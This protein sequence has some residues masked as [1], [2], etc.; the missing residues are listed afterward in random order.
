MAKGLAGALVW[1]AA[2][3]ALAGEAQKLGIADFEQGD[4]GFA[5]HL[6]AE[7]PGAKGSFAPAEGG[8]TGKRAAKIAADFA[9]GGVYVSI[10]KKLPELDRDFAEVRLWVRSTDV[11]GL[12][13]RLVDSTGQVHQQRPKFEPDGQWQLIRIT[14]FD[15]GPG[16]QSWGGAKDRKWHPPATSIALNPEKGN[17]PDRKGT[18]WVDG[19]EATLVAQ[20]IIPPLAVRPAR[21]GNVFLTTEDVVL[22]VETQGDRVAWEITDFWGDPVA[23]GQE[24][25]A[26]NA[27][28]VRPP[29]RTKGYFL[30]RL[31]ATRDG[32]PVAE[33]QTAFGVVEPVDVRK[34][35]GNRFGVQAHFAQGWDVD[36]LPLLARAGIGSIRDEH[37]WAQVEKKRGEFAFPEKSDRYMAEA[38]RLGLE[39]LVTMSFEN[40][41]HDGGLT[42]HTPEGR[43]AYA[44]YGQAIL[45]RYGKQVRHLEVWNEY[46]GT[47][48]KGPAAKDRPKSYAQML[49]AAWRGIKAER[50]DVRVLGSA[51]VLI[52]IPYFEGIFRNGGL[53]HMDAVVIHPYRGQPEGVEDEVAELQELI[54]K[55]NG[56]RDKPIWATETGRWDRSEYAW[57]KGQG[58][59]ELGRR[60]VARYLARQM[61]LLLSRGVERV[62]WYLARDYHDF[63]TM[64]LLRR[65]DS[66]MGRY[67]VAAPYMAYATLIRQ[68]HGAIPVRREATSERTYVHLF[69]RGDQQVR[70]CWA[71]SPAHVAL[72]TGQPVTVVDIVGGQ[73]T[74]D[75]AGGEVWLTLSDAPVYVVG[76]VESIVEGAAA[77]FAI[78]GEQ[79]VDTLDD[80]ALTCRVADG[81]SGHVA[82]AG[83]KHPVAPGDNRLVVS[84]ADTTKPG[85]HTWRYRLVVDGKPAGRG[86]LVA[87]VVDPVSFPEPPR[88]EDGTHLRVRLANSSARV[89]YSVERVTCTLPWMELRHRFA[90]ALPHGK[91]LAL[92]LPVGSLPPYRA[93]PATVVATLKGRSGITASAPISDNPCP[94]RSIEPDG[95]L[96]DWA[97]A[98]GIDLG[99]CAQ[100][101]G[102]DKPDGEAWIAWDEGGFHFALRLRS[103][104]ASSLQLALAPLRAPLR[105]WYEFQ[106]ALGAD[107]ATLT[108]TL[109]PAAR[110]AGAAVGARASTARADGLTV[111]EVSVPWAEFAPITRADG[112]FRLAFL[113][114][115][116]QPGGRTRWI[117]WGTG[118]RMGKTPEGFRVCRFAEAGTAAARTELE[119][120]PTVP[121]MQGGHVVAD[122]RADYGKVQG[123]HD[124]F[125]GFCDGDAKGE[126]DGAS[127][128]GAYTDDDFEPMKHIVTVWGYQWGGPMQYL[129]LTRDGGHPQAQAGRPVWAVRRWR[130]TVDGTVRLVGHFAHTG[131]GDGIEGRILVGGVQVYGRRVGG[132]G[133]PAQADFEADVAVREGIFVDF[134]ITPGPGTDT[135]FD[136]STF[137]V[138]II[139]PTAAGR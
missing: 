94:K 103:S 37:Y 102:K 61:T 78:A 39:P 115:E 119:D 20:R 58:L 123:G 79:T 129:S 118:I 55:H 35:P 24:T 2:A 124:W 34:M 133:N 77:K 15:K 64:G 74:L 86:S 69:R 62:Y 137:H 114:A 67:N 68:L 107:G 33:M 130:S 40:P 128:S 27:A 3:A 117:E 43:D 18:L 110:Q 95:R 135:S 9:G 106:V 121:A 127:P 88:V 45:R 32:K 56:G 111:C 93:F 11:N 54:R 66:P 83:G 92:D 46:N 29:S 31:S 30:V 80:L 23:E 122:S 109:A 49:E 138:R 90:V 17:F 1:L 57:E 81:L 136:A 87:R 73:S 120:L 65:P 41:L 71:T 134:A 8:K 75:P 76:P 59:F 116:G 12:T 98:V 48:C 63:R 36:I 28:T 100:A 14:A 72:R 44:R 85:T 132:Q 26:N 108:R 51:A 125:Y 19:I 4:D 99:T 53:E 22:P 7:F 104:S 126:G 16:Y 97:G 5:F 25:V 82:L 91:G 96:D 21:L 10:S 6:G 112:A 131:K 60:N 13:F 38:A 70:V 52:P 47:W 89:E 105:G 113:V 101:T 50:A 42:P 139:E 84:G